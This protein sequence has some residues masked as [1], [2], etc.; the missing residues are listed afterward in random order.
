MDRRK[1]R[2]H[3]HQS[4]VEE[5]DFTRERQIGELGSI[6]AARKSWNV[7]ALTELYNA[8]RGVEKELER[9]DKKRT[10][11][12]DNLEKQQELKKQI[13]E[14]E[15]QEKQYK[16]ERRELIGTLGA[17]A[18]RAYRG[19][20]LEKEKFVG[21]FAEI[22]KIAGEIKSRENA[23]QEIAESRQEKNLL[24]KMSGGTRIALQKASITRLEKKRDGELPKIG[25]ALAETGKVEDIPDEQ[26][27]SVTAAL[28][29]Q[30]EQHREELERKAALHEDLRQL[31]EV[32]EQL[33]DGNSPEKELK[34]LETESGEKRDEL[35]QKNQ[36]LGKA[37][38]LQPSLE[39]KVSKET[40]TVLGR[41]HELSEQKK[42]HQD[43]IHNLQALIEIDEL[44]EGV[45]KKE[46]QIA[47]LE[48]RIAEDREQ[49]EK[50]RD[51]LA[52]D[53]ERI[54]E[55]RNVTVDP[56]ELKPEKSPRRKENSEKKEP[57][58][59][60]EVEK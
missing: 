21:I 10:S 25:E 50:T 38:L 22:D 59:T 1:S 11:I 19:G 28:K 41:I 37:Y 15:E 47:R 27:R 26:V 52:A 13:E 54:Q 29:H 58:E 8:S 7:D 43:Q 46:E 55:L 42:L 9:L 56:D 16:S 32:L 33:T 23:L 4:A 51:E 44:Q 40:E 2:I 48:K 49:V 24:K 53:H 17:H 39:E 5:L 31:E 14:I 30:E 57:A 18:Y 12:S 45:K 6:L 35:Q 60:P 34:R 20:G 3:E 36:E